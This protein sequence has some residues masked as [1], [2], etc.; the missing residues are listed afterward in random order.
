MKESIV[1][2]TIVLTVVCLIAAGLLGYSYV[3]TKDKIDEQNKKALN[4]QLKQVFPDAT[5]FKE[6]TNSQEQSYFT[7]LNGKDLIG[8]AAVAESPGYSSVLQILVGMNLSKQV[9]GVRIIYQS[10][11]PG[12]GTEAAKPLF[13][14]QFTGKTSKETQLKKFGGTID[15]ITG[16]TI[17]S[18]AVTAGVSDVLINRLE[19]LVSETSQSVKSIETKQS[20][21][22]E[23]PVETVTQTN[24]STSTNDTINKTEGMISALATK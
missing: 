14:N 24:K 16:A 13:Y 17:S 11:T 7:A 12:L 18:K 19:K 2:S 5:E 22:A 10:E 20:S 9:T 4:E 15:G 1:K 21:Q 3:L 8:Y 23:K 6:E